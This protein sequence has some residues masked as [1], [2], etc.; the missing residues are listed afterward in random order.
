MNSGSGVKA[1]ARMGALAG[2]ALAMLLALASAPSLADVYGYVDEN[3]VAHLSDRALDSRYFLFRKEPPKPPATEASPS[4]ASLAQPA[5]TT[6]QPYDT[7]V[8]RV[9]REQGVEVALLHAVITVESGYNANA[10]SPKGA[11]GLMQ[12]MPDTA[13]RFGVTDIWNPLDN[14]RG[15]ARYLRALLGAFNDN[16][17]LV[18]AAYN[19]GEGAVAGAGNAIPAY[20]ETRRYVP[21]VLEYYQR[22][23]GVP[24]L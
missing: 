8:T 20:P 3:G 13:K 22:Y 10:K 5:D 16:L 2:P 7:L 14:I 17:Q 11:S 1:A 19:A 18:L 23:G 15:G 21:R 24:G 6:R 4:A 9:A 12:L